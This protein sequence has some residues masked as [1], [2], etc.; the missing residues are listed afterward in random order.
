MKNSLHYDVRKVREI[1]SYFF[2]IEYYYDNEKVLNEAEKDA[3]YK[4][5][6]TFLEAIN[7]L[8]NELIEVAGFTPGSNEALVEEKVQE[9]FYNIGKRFYGTEKKELL[10]FFRHIY[11][12]LFGVETGPRIGTFAN[13]YGVEAFMK[14]IYSNV[15]IPFH[16]MRKPKEQI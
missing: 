1:A 10:T 13:I 11:M 8:E 3:Y 2:F 5:A 9:A 4:Q 7:A 15:S 12:L 14:D 6:T 16:K